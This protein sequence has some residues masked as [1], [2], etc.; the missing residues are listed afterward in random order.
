MY[1]LKKKKPKPPKLQKKIR[2]VVNPAWGLEQW[3]VGELE[4][5]GQE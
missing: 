3:V 1:T 4:K 2:F 5:G